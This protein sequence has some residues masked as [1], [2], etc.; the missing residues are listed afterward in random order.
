MTEYAPATA[1][2]ACEIVRAARGDGRTL[3]I[4]GGGTRAAL[5]R[6]VDADDVLITRALSGIVFY[7]P[8]EM[9]LRARAGTP[10]AQIEAALDDNGQM[11]PFEP[12]DHRRLFGSHGEPTIG[13][14]AAC[15]ISGPRRIRAGAARDSLIGVRFVNGAG[16]DLS[17]GGRVMKNVTGLDLVKLHCGAYGTLGLLTEATFKLLP[18]TETS[19]SL[20]LEGL[21]ESAAVEAMSDALKT[22]FEVSAAA[23]LP[24]NG[25]S[26]TVF[27]L[28]HFNQSVAYRCEA[29]AKRLAAFGTAGVIDAQASRDLWRDIRDVALLREPHDANIWRVAIRPSAVVVYLAALREAGLVFRYLLD[30][31]GGLLWLS[32]ASEPADAAAIIRAALPAGAGHAM[33]ARASEAQRRATPVFQPLSDAVMKLSANVKASIDPAGLF[34]PGRMYA[35]I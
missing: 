30:H 22:P 6:P 9:V 11:L 3:R 33:L 26:R 19:A 4:E 24:D 25:R 31:G 29:L 5:G 28:E 1:A 14:L 20:V 12:M 32:S 7:E 8:A 15:N 10:L 35:G 27:R 18:K 2:E 34:N 16:E 17:S 23:Y 21:D 13:A